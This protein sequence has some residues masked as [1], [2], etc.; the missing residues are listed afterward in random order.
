MITAEEAYRL[1]HPT[2]K[3]LIQKTVDKIEKSIIE[4]AEKYKWPQMDIT[5]DA[6]I[7]NDIIAYLQDHGYRV[8]TH[9]HELY[10]ND[11]T[12]NIYWG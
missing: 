7:V 12:I 1:A 11:I 8:M 10:S 3:D 4:V 5:I 9:Y 6:S 2:Q